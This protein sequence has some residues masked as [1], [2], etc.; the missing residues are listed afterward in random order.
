MKISV[1]IVPT[2]LAAMASAVPVGFEDFPAELLNVKR[3]PEAYKL[4]ENGTL[5]TTTENADIGNI[6]WLDPTE[7][8]TANNATDVL[9][10]RQDYQRTQNWICQKQDRTNTQP[11]LDAMY[12]HFGNKWGFGS[13]S[14]PQFEARGTRCLG[15]EFVVKNNAL[16]TRTEGDRYGVFARPLPDGK[17]VSQ[18]VTSRDIEH[19]WI[20]YYFTRVGDVS[21]ASK[22]EWRNCN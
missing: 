21:W 22:I 18:C 3:D 6:P 10:K 4:Y 11:Y 19:Y 20:W 17:R 8:F 16:G 1:L 14:I 5:P 15:F 12:S 13:M 2:A 9:A 7:E